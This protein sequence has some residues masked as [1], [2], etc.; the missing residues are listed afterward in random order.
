MAVTSSKIPASAQGPNKPNSSHSELA[1]LPII[2][3]PLLALM[4]LVFLGAPRL[5]SW[6]R[7]DFSLIDE[8]TSS[9]S[10]ASARHSGTQTRD[11]PH[12]NAVAPPKTS[13]ALRSELS[14]EVHAAW[15]VPNRDMTWYVLAKIYYVP[16]IPHILLIVDIHPQRHLSQCCQGYRFD[17]SST[18]RAYISCQLHCRLV[19]CRARHMPY[20]CPSLF[21]TQ[22]PAPET[23]PSPLIEVWTDDIIYIV[24]I[25]ITSRCLLSSSRLVDTTLLLSYT[26]S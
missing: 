11:L 12:L 5:C 26:I 13:Q 18:V 23:T 19:L 15:A 8:S 24:Y 4:A 9:S 25:K 3:L 10:S 14:H 21:I 17:P 22:T 6:A 1:W 16:H 7:Y 2:I 20:M